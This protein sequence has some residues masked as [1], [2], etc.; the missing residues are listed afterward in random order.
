MLKKVFFAIFFGITMIGT[1]NGQK[2]D[3][4]SIGGE[5]FKFFPPHDWTFAL[6]GRLRPDVKFQGN[7]CDTGN[8][9]VIL[10][11]NDATSL[12]KKLNE[13]PITLWT[14]FFEKGRRIKGTV[15]FLFLYKE[16]E[17]EYLVFEKITEANY[18]YGH[19]GF[20]WRAEENK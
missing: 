4:V 15:Q 19:F 18:Y 17:K 5:E 9:V 7:S 11:K 20:Y 12:I 16:N 14:S 10:L 8:K 3:V 2:F 13:G 6:G 1:V